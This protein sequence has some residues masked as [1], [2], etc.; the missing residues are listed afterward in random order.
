MARGSPVRFQPEAH[1]QSLGPLQRLLPWHTVVT[2]AKGNVLEK[3]G[4]EQL[5]VR[6]LKHQPHPAADLA[7]VGFLHGR[8]VG[9]HLARLRLLE[10]DEKVQQRRFA[11]AVGSQKRHPLPA[12]QGEGHALQHGLAPRVAETELADLQHRLAHGHR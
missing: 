12:M 1:Q 4:H 3:R 5:V 10:P 9:Q 2:R 6:V 11:R 7:Q 8:A